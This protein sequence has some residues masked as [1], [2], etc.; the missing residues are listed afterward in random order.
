MDDRFPPAA[1]ASDPALRARLRNLLMARK[2]EQWQDAP[3][4]RAGE[5]RD[6]P[7]FAQQRVWFLARMGGGAGEAYHVPL[8]FRMRG[9][10]DGAALRRALDRIAD[11]HEALRTTFADDGGEPRLHVGVPG[12]GFELRSDDLS[13]MADP[14][15]ALDALMAQ[16]Q[17]LPFDLERGPLARGRLVRL[18]DEDHVLLVTLH[19]IVSDGWSIGV[20]ARELGALYR[21]YAQGGGDPLEPLAVQYADYAAWQRRWL[22]GDALERQAAY[23]RET[24]SGAPPL[25]E[26][27]TDRR[28]PAQQDYAGGFVRLDLDEALT[29]KLK[30]LGQRHGT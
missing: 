19:H 11:R 9:D 13:G 20:L 21:A 1:P 15:A 2:A 27:P 28:R 23:W 10:L 17:A 26:L 3:I 8:G 6:R 12:R 22:S 24:L 4:G 7:S 29:A 18:A 25:L 14:E 30:A 16:E 5:D